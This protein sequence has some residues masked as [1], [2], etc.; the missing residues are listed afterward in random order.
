MCILW[1]SVSWNFLKKAFPQ[2]LHRWGFSPVWRFWWSASQDFLT[3]AFPH[4]LHTWDFFICLVCWCSMSW[5]L[6]LRSSGWNGS[7]S[8][9]GQ[10]FPSAGGSVGLFISQ[11][12]LS[13]SKLEFDVTLLPCKSNTSWLCLN[14]VLLWW[15]ELSSGFCSSHCSSLFSTLFF[16]KCSS[17]WPSTFQTSRKEKKNEFLYLL[18]LE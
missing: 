4:S 8:A 1:C 9:W 13:E 16:C 5:D 15:P 10:D 6:V 14:R 12:G 3:N 11:F 7:L 17:R 18:D 2:R